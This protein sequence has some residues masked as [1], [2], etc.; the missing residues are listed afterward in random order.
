MG[1]PAENP[2]GYD[3]SNVLRYIPAYR[4]GL[5]LIHGAVDDNVHLS[6]TFQLAAGLQAAGKPFQM[7]IYPDR[8]HGI[9]GTGYRT[10]YYRLM[11]EFILNQ[12]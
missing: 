12:L 6:N 3:A 9:H 4:N 5:L 8:A 1:L 11:A 2:K 7:M 10:H